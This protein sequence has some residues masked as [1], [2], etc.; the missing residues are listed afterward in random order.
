VAPI[1]D[2]SADSW[3]DER[4]EYRFSARVDRPN[5]NVTLR[6]PTFEGGRIDWYAFDYDA[7]P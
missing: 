4:L 2:P 5:A 7:T 6:A 3:V 1:R